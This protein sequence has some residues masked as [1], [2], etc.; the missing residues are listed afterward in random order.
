MSTNDSSHVSDSGTVFNLTRFTDP[1]VL[2]SFLGIRP[3]VYFFIKLA[4]IK[5][6]KS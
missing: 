4:F 5:K 3:I 2:E 1:D 6:N